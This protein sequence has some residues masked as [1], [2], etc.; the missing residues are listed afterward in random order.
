M[1][2]GFDNPISTEVFSEPVSLN[3][4]IAYLAHANLSGK[5]RDRHYCGV[6][7]VLPK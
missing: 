5:E 7:R 4:F 1:R 2:V 3:L 6:K